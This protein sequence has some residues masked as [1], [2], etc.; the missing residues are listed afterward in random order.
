M[1]LACRAMASKGIILFCLMV[2]RAS[3]KS[4]LETG[5]KKFVEKVFL[6]KH[7]RK[8]LFLKGYF[9]VF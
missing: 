4:S 2:F 6:A 8:T 9:L 5:G 3:S 7:V 1:W